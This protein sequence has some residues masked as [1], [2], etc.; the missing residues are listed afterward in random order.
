MSFCT[1]LYK[2]PLVIILQKLVFFYENCY[3]FIIISYW[4]QKKLF[5]ICWW[6]FQVNIYLC[7]NC[8][9]LIIYSRWDRNKMATVLQKMFRE[10][11]VNSLLLY[12]YYRILIKLTL[13]LKQNYN[14]FAIW[15]NSHGSRNKI[16]H[17]FARHFQFREGKL[18]Y[19]DYINPHWGWN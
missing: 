4:D 7:D 2:K 3:I 16:G 17:Y 5:T 18:L 19:F 8:C 12:G 13:G 15:L 10:R 6:N 14:D 9:T 1:L 11:F